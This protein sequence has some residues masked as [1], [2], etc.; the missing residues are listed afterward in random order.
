MT[1]ELFQLPPSLSPKLAWLRKHNLTVIHPESA[2]F[3]CVLDDENFGKG[4]TEEEAIID[5]CVK[6]QM[7][8]YSQHTP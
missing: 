5:F 7:K 2:K 1:D 4:A 6:T 8:H 3:E